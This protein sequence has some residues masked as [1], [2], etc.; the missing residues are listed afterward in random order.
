MD[1]KDP[2]IFFP[3][4]IALNIIAYLLNIGIGISWD[5]ILRHKTTV[6]KKE[7]LSSLLTLLINITIAIP[8]FLL[9]TKG[10]ILFSDMDLWLTFIILFLLMDFLM[11]FLHWASHNIRYLKK[12]YLKHHEH[13][14]SFNCISLYY[15]SPWESILFG[16]LLTMVAILLPLNIYGFILFLVFNWSYGVITHLNINSDNPYFLIFTTNSFH[17]N[18]H[19]SFCK[20]YGFYTF[21]WDRI[22]NTEK[23]NR[24]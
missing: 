18:H 8:G 15:M 14:E 6:T 9:W 12:I 5:K 10:I 3:L 20:N 1:I 21:I 19:V 13:S 22:F 17:K 4:L 2:N 24:I 7:I 11:Y 16:L 23:N